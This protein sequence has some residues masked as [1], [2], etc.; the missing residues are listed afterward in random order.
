MS[1]TQAAS[2]DLRKRAEEI[3]RKSTPEEDLSPQRRQEMFHE[4]RVH[5]VELE[6]Q[7]EELRRVQKQLETSHERYFNLYDLAPVGYLTLSEEGIILEA[8]LTTSSLLGLNRN[9]LLHRPFTHFVLFAEE[10][11]YQEHHRLLFETG[12]PQAFDLRLVKR[13]TSQFWARIETNLSREPD[14]A[15]VCFAAM[16]DFTQRKE[17]EEAAHAANRAKDHFIAMLS[18]ELRTPLTPVLAMASVL[19]TEADLPD[20]LR[21][22]IELISR[23]VAIE[24]ALID[25]L[26][27]LTRISRGKI[28]LQPKTVDVHGC[29]AKVEEICQEEIKAKRLDIRFD[30]QATRHQVWADPIRLRQ[31]FWNLL[32]NAVKFTPE[33]GRITLR[34]TNV[35]E[36]IK[37]E[38]ADTGIGIDPE[39]MP[40]I[41]E[42]FKQGNQGKTRQF[43]GLGLGL[44]I[45]KTVV[46]LH[47]GSLTAFS[48]GRNQGATFTV[49]LA[50]LP[51]E[52][53]S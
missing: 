36:V 8:N 22:D 35:C 17:A 48:E 50:A 11:I 45:A 20:R 38:I 51:G 9:A 52:V 23:N 42:P 25:D 53:E 27:D 13:D 12:A 34:T 15:P 24:A 43:G 18:H 33:E 49:E 2:D 21:P 39:V 16:I 47:Q 31:V 37:I 14:C 44:S 26:L 32:K 3:T 19:Q 4:L 7:N 29:L 40:E 1:E 41:F 10:A 46:E 6:M 30:L 5:Q 28:N